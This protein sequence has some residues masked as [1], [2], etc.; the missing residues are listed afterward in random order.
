MFSFAMFFTFFI[1]VSIITTMI[2]LDQYNDTDEEMV[3]SKNT[4]RISLS[5]DLY[6]QELGEPDLPFEE[7]DGEDFLE[8]PEPNEALK[9]LMKGKE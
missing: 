5:Q 9:K 8:S 4:N 1:L 2:I 6:S 7:I 3:F